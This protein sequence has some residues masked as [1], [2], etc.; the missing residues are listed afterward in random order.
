M[1]TFKVILAGMIL[2]IAVLVATN[3]LS[4]IIKLRQNTGQKVMFDG[5]VVGHVVVCRYNGLKKFFYVNN[6]MEL[7][8][9]SFYERRDAIKGCR[10]AYIETMTVA[11]S[12]RPHS[13]S[14]PR[15]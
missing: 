7:V 9:N 1:Y 14:F 12:S 2:G 4:Q 10:K 6:D 15:A 13:L 3:Y 5:K 11:N 8:S